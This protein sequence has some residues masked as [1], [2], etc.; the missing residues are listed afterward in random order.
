MTILEAVAKSHPAVEEQNVHMLIVSWKYP[1]NATDLLRNPRVT[2]SFLP[3]S[4]IQ[5]SKWAKHWII[6]EVMA[7]LGWRFD[8][9]I[10]ADSDACL[11]WGTGLTITDREELQRKHPSPFHA[12]HSFLTDDRP[13]VGL[14]R[15]LETGTTS[16][17]FNR[18]SSPWHLD[19]P[20][21]LDYD[22]QFHAVS[23]DAILF[24][25]FDLAFEPV[26]WNIGDVSV[27]YRM[28]GLFAG[29]TVSFNALEIDSHTVEST[30]DDYQTNFKGDEFLPRIAY[31]FERTWLPLAHRVRKSLPEHLQSRALYTYWMEWGGGGGA[32]DVLPNQSHSDLCWQLPKDPAA[33]EAQRLPHKR[34]SSAHRGLV[35][36]L[37]MEGMITNFARRIDI[38][39]G[40]DPD[41]TQTIDGVNYTNAFVE[42][43][44]VRE[45]A[46]H[47]RV[48]EMVAAQAIY[49]AARQ[50]KPFLK[51]MRQR[52]G[53]MANAAVEEYASLSTLEEAAEAF[54][55]DG[56]EGV[57]EAD[58]SKPLLLHLQIRSRL[59]GLP[60]HRSAFHDPRLSELPHPTQHQRFYA[61][62]NTMEL[63][64]A[65]AHLCERAS[66]LPVDREASVCTGREDVFT[67]TEQG[68]LSTCRDW[69]ILPEE[70][71]AEPA[72]CYR[73]LVQGFRY[74]VL[75]RLS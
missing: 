30:A 16:T 41:G 1:I 9:V 75:V 46:L 6:M 66:K 51:V 33:C 40:R 35:S 43:A 58:G 25:A 2:T 32:T 12:F 68:A 69:L 8:Y 7:A 4:T 57:V 55:V 73:E 22:H 24:Y 49:S 61:P 38:V 39:R 60:A 17:P 21:V 31:S 18:S 28:S 64:S 20:A 48:Y 34:W 27:C 44:F 53:A 54:R 36:V 19:K 14:P 45:I 15:T 74:G 13:A 65:S 3:R 71:F 10:R 5:Q 47:M 62:G 50:T 42:A 29:R 70:H 72:V 63:W 56:G 59:A 52:L 67:E 23:A 37:L 11:A 26:N